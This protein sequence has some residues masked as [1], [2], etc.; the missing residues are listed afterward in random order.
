MLVVSSSASHL[1]E[2]CPGHA[3]GGN[4]DVLE[5]GVLQPGSQCQQEELKRLCCIGVEKLEASLGKTMC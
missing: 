1:Q 3:K 4:V 2:R 5:K